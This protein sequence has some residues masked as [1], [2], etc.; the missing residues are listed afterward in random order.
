MNQ[1]KVRGHSVRGHLYQ[2]NR[3]VTNGITGMVN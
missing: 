2:D 1:S 3:F